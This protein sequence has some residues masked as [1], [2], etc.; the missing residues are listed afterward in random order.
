LLA[1]MLVVCGVLIGWRYLPGLLGEWIGFM[2]G[3]MTTPFLLEASF[4]ILGLTVVV[5]INVWRQRHAGDELVY[6]EQVE[7]AE[8]L[9]ERARWALYRDAPLAGEVPSLQTQAEGALAIGDY[10]S[11][12]E[13]LAAMPEEVLKRP[14]IL[15]LRLEM[16]R[17]TGKRELAEKLETELRALEIGNR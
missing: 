8:N 17:A 14:D 12:A 6:L 1:I 5:A 15:A 7:G 9:P 4:V 11:A 3:V 13:C 2:V 10:E 16:A